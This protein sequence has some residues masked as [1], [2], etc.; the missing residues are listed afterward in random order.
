MKYAVQLLDATKVLENVADCFQG[1]SA[2]IRKL[3]DDWFLE[4]SAFEACTAAHEVY[5]IADEILR[6]I[7]RV[8]ALYMGLFSPLRIGYV[9]A[10]NEAGVPT[11]R[12]LRDITRFNVYLSPEELQTSHGGQSLGASL[13]GRA[14]VNTNVH[15]ALALVGENELQWPQIYDI[16]EFLGG[17]NGIVKR[18]WATREVVGKYWR[19]ANI[20][21][22]LGSPKKKPLPADPPSISEARAFALNFLK[23]WISSQL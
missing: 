12:P 7:H 9:Q 15:E 22:H 19:T 6:L 18:K 11:N 3:G 5:P 1:D 10:C 8:F 2:R 16:L 13:V 20:H 21:R 14:T 4:S 17:M 23:R